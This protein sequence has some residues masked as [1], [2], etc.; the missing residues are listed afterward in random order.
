M[1]TSSI[2]LDAK[3]KSK[4]H[5]PITLKHEGGVPQKTSENKNGPEWSTL[6]VHQKKNSVGQQEEGHGV[7]HHLQLEHHQSYL[8]NHYQNDRG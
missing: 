8:M 2:L 5:P 6:L 4:T 3:S 7:V 1:R